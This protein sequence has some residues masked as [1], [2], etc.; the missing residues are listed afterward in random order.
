VPRTPLQGLAFLLGFAIALWLGPATIAVEPAADPEAAQ[1]EAALYAQVNAVRAQHHLVPLVRQPDLDG[2]A[3]AHSGDMAARGYFAHES[4]EGLNPLHR[5][6]RAQLDGFSMAAEN[7]GKTTKPSPAQE[8]ATGWMH[9]TDH[10]TNI[11][12]PAFNATGLGVARG[13]D[14]SWIATQVFVTYPR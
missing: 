10:R 3:R 14:G 12:A 8:I 6:E 2:V 13:R 11:L 4:P 1:L 7:L 9:S 5:L